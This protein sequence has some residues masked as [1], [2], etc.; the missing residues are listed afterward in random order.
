MIFHEN[1]LPADDSHEIS[2]LICYFWK[3]SKIW[4]CRLLQII[5]GALRDN[6]GCGAHGKH[7]VD[8]FSVHSHNKCF[9]LHEAC[10]VVLVNSLHAGK[11]FT[12]F[13][14]LLFFFKIIVFEKFFQEYHQSVK[15]FGSRSNVGPDLG[16][17]CL[18]RLS[19]NDIG[20]WRVNSFS[21]WCD[22]YCYVSVYWYVDRI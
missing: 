5:G 12:I 1:C 19:A 17:S 18:K 22:L 4:N 14:R 20:K 21:S 7:L 16:P 9:F 3:T 11:F 6:I 10:F 2:C 15:Q 8:M 13:C